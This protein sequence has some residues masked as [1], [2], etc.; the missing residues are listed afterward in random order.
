MAN[1]RTSIFP[2]PFGAGIGCETAARRPRLNRLL[3]FFKGRSSAVL[4]FHAGVLLFNWPLL[5]ISGDKGGE[6][7]FTYLF[8]VWAVIVVLLMV[9]GYAV[10]RSAASDR[11]H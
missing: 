3:G 5:S 7:L 4:L 6:S 1:T 9:M 11:E 10:R 8:T 2:A